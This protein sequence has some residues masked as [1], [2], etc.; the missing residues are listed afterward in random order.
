MFLLAHCGHG[1]SDDKRYFCFKIK[2]IT[3]TYL[4][5]TK[6]F[7][8]FLNLRGLVGIDASVTEL[9]KNYEELY[10]MGNELPPQDLRRFVLTDDEVIKYIKLPHHTNFRYARLEKLPNLKKINLSK[11]EGIDTLIMHN[12]VIE[13]INI[14]KS[15]LLS[16]L[17]C[18]GCKIKKITLPANSPLKY[19]NCSNNYIKGED[20]DKLIEA[21][22]KTQ[23]G[24]LCIKNTANENNEFTTEMVEKAKS[25]G[26]KVVDSQGKEYLGEV[27][28]I[29]NVNTAQKN[30]MPYYDLMGRK[31]AYP[32]HKGIYIYNKKKVI[33]R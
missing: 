19:I 30:D 25:K 15:K 9:P 11:C 3:E 7:T 21:L 29:F 13:E 5:L 32:T 10:F 16:F 8:A 18:S 31:F 23:D 2:K 17:D 1:L 22:P 26:W 14:E 24:E 28:S 6:P 33:V 27:T 20:A 4:L 12:L